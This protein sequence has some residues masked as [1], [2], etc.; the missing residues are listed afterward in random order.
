MP[1]RV[2]VSRLAT[3]RARSLRRVAT[4]SPTPIR[5][6]ACVVIV[7]VSWTRPCCHEAVTDRTVQGADLLTGLSHRQYPLL[8]ADDARGCQNGQSLGA[9]RLRGVDADL[10]AS[11]QGVEDPTRCLAS[12]LT[13]TLTSRRST[14]LDGFTGAHR[15]ADPGVLGIAEPVDDIQGQAGLG[16]GPAD[17]EV[18]DPAA[19]HCGQLVAVPDERDPGPGLVSDSQQGAGGVLVEH[20][21]LV[22]QQ[23]VTGRQRRLRRRAGV[24]LGGV[25]VAVTVTLAGRQSGPDAVVVPAVAVLMGEPG[26]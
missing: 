26:R 17:G 9:F 2:Q 15:E 10:V 18:K 4:R 8:A 19:A 14:G 25:R 12:R 6:P 24:G 5:S 7:A 22:D 13:P 23:Q 16:C 11:Q 21:G 20:P 3:C 1:V